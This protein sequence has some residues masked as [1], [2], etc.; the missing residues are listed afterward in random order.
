[1]KTFELE[2]DDE[3]ELNRLDLIYKEIKCDLLKA[4]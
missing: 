3:I 2:Q 4:Q 1:L